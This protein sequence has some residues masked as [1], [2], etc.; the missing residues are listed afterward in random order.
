MSRMPYQILKEGVLYADYKFF[1]GAE[2]LV[3]VDEDYPLKLEQF[4]WNDGDTLTV[5]ITDG[6]IC[7]YRNEYEEKDLQR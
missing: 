4:K 2:G 6:L 3:F 1:A 7:L 5:K